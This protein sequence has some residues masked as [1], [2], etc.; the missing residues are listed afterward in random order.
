MGQLK[1]T[2]LETTTLG[3]FAA[4]V[5]GRWHL[6]RD[7]SPLEGTFTLVLRRINGNW[8]IIHDHTSKAEPK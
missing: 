3:D 1:F 6:T 8:V 5:L 7:S 4:L 2:Q